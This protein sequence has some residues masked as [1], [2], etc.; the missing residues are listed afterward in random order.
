MT[1][2]IEIFWSKRRI[3]E[4]YLNIAETGKGYFGSTFLDIGGGNILPNIYKKK[5]DGHEDNDGVF[6]KIFSNLINSF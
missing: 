2:L 4:V 6:T 5:Q 3:L 1:I